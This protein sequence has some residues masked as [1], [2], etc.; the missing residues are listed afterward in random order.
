MLRYADLAAELQ[1]GTPGA[2]RPLPGADVLAKW[3]Q[4]AVDL[5]RVARGELRLQRNHR[6]LGRGGVDVAP[7][8]G[9]AV[10]VD[11]DRHPWL[12]TADAEHQV[13]A[14]RPDTGER[15]QEGFVARQCA[16]MLLHQ[17]TCDRGDLPRL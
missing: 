7:A 10:D 13:S 2:V 17:Q 12:A 3:D 1:D 14:L 9:H 6:L 5:E 4:Q 16:A 8:V 11:V 15:E